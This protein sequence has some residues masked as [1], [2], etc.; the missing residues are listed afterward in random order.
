MT[1]MAPRTGR[2]GRMTLTVKLFAMLRERA[3]VDRLDLDIAEGTT[4]ADALRVLARSEELDGALNGLSAVIA[5][6]REYANPG[7][8]LWSGDELALIPPL[9]GG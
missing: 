6:N 1:A 7:R 5:V 3:G 9:S 2:A 4:V 8:T